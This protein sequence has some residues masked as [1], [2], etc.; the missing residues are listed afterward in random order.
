MSGHVLVVV[1]TSP[2]PTS[3][4]VVERL[5]GVADQLAHDATAVVFRRRIW[6]SEVGRLLEDLDDRARALQ[7]DY[8]AEA[9]RLAEICS[10]AAIQAGVQLEIAEIDL[11]DDPIEALAALARSHDYCVLPV[12]PSAEDELDVLAALLY[13]AG[14]PVVLVPGRLSS[15]PSPQWEH[16][17]VAWRSNAQASR[18][19]KEAMPLLR[20]ATAVSVLVIREDGAGLNADE[21]LEAVRYLETRG[22][23]A[24][25]RSVPAGG[26]AVGP[27]I[28]RFMDENS[29]DLLVMGAP[30]KPFEADFKRHSKG[31]DVIDEARW[32]ILISA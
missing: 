8:D 6:T 11:G 23:S 3:G 18:A 14:R 4:H 28:A 29:A 27:R 15:P 5:V 20:K 31:V 2:Q 24:D 30:S 19:M 16:A 12:G 9:R 10:A 13:R 1:Q 32:V 21:P 25:V 22:V 26:Q 7:Q 17:V